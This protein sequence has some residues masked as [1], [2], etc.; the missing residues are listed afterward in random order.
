MACPGLAPA[1]SLSIRDLNKGVTSLLSHL[2]IKAQR[3]G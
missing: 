2:Q 1:L 3:D